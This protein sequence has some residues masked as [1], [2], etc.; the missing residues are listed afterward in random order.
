VRRT[1]RELRENLEEFVLQPDHALLFVG[2]TDN[3]V[4]YVLKTQE[5]L[6]GEDPSNVYFAFADPFVDA[7]SYALTIA[8]RFRDLFG[9][10]DAHRAEHGE[11]PLSPFPEVVFAPATP[12]AARIVHAMEH[13][14]QYL[15]DRAE[16]R[17]VVSLLPLSLG[18]TGPSADGYFQLLASFAAH[19]APAPWMQYGRIIGRDHR[20]GR[21][22]STAIA[23]AGGQG[24]LAFDVDFSVEAMAGD[25]AQDAV[26]PGL[27]LAER[28]QA[29]LQ[30]AAIDMSYRRFEESG[31]KYAILYDYYGRSGAPL[32]QALC[33]LG[34][35]DCLRMNG[36]HRP[37]LERYQQGLALVMATPSPIPIQAPPLAD[38]SPN[39]QPGMHPNAPPVMLNLLLAA[40]EASFGV[41]DHEGA[42]GY[43]ESASKIAAKLMNPYAAADALE[44]MGDAERAL[45]RPADALRTWRDVEKLVE[46]MKYDQRLESVLG[47]IHALYDEAAMRKEAREVFD[48]REGVRLRMQKGAS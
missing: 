35:G 15:P 2:C 36:S 44:R 3:D 31:K 23:R 24:M 10:A 43:F 38:G 45:G 7:P 16:H 40:G 17:V 8:Q 25:L 20:A 42:R 46:P 19:G 12:P 13:V 5:Q 9:L 4:P 6:Q 37:A 11:P 1:L 48:K 41:K 28:M 30:L 22:G 33:L 27:P 39:P 47:R 34:V 21:P 32:M 18:T 29:T 14:A 26:D